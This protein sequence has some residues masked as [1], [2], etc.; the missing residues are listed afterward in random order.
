MVAAPAV[1][2]CFG[3]GAYEYDP[4]KAKSPLLAEAGY[5]NGFEASIWVLN[6]NQTRV[7]VCQ[8][9]QA[10]LQ[11]VNHLQHRGN[12][13]RQLYFQDFRRGA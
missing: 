4:E 13:I 12:G 8:A 9:V 2:G 5:P 7:E 11:D 10:M 1:F 6:D 3:P